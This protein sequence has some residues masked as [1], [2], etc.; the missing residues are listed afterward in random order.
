MATPKKDNTVV[1]GKNPTTT[2]GTLTPG[3]TGALPQSGLDS[4]I[5]KNL[6]N[7]GVSGVKV[8][9]GV[10]ASN[11]VESLSKG[12]MNKI[13]PWL[14]KFG[15]SKTS[16]ADYKTAKAYLKENYSTYIDNS[17]FNVTK[18][19]KMFSDNATGAGGT[20]TTG[21]KSNGV[22]QYITKKSPA[23]VNEFVDKTLLTKIGSKNVTPEIRQ[24]I[25][26]GIQK[27]I[28][29]GTTTTST[30]DKTGKSTVVSTPGYSDERAAAMIEGVVKEK[31]APQYGQQ[32]Q[33][34][35]YDFMQT[36]NSQRSGQ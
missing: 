8:D 33:L 26:D 13:I 19:V 16:I 22:T 9:K 4:A 36:A 34:N 2:G 23:L 31:A 10:Q 25:I 7:V 29:E 35:F 28:N 11:W 14:K 5:N 21:T 20:G 17:E 18:L 3:S 24:E 15:A 1:I 12:E 27:L 6:G 32:K 30:M